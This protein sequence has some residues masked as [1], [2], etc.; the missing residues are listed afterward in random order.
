MT[1]EERPL[2]HFA[3]SNSIQ[4]RK[5]GRKTQKRNRKENQEKTEE[6]G[7][8]IQTKKRNNT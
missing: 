6:R 7:R 8:E 3:D 4:R 5:K 1:T 2:V